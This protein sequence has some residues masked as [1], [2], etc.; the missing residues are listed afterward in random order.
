VG[1]IQLCAK[2]LGEISIKEHFCLSSCT[3]D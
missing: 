2:N 1:T 3:Q